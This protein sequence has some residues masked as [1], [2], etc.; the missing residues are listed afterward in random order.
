MSTTDQAQTGAP[1]PPAPPTVYHL[2]NQPLTL[3]RPDSFAARQDVIELGADNFNRTLGAALGLC[4]RASEKK[5]GVSY[6]GSKFNAGVYGGAVIDVLQARGV[7][8]A[9]ILAVGL[10]AWR[11]CREGMISEAEVDEAEDFSDPHAEPSTSA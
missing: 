7:P 11:L 2:G 3:Q 9:Q 4:W 1:T 10:A 8:L 5:L 6:Q